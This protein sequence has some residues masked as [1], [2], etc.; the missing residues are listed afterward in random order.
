MEICR[1]ATGCL[2]RVSAALETPS[3]V[4]ICLERFRSAEKVDKQT[5]ATEYASATLNRLREL[6]KSEHGEKHLQS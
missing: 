1:M 6:L 5:A 2:N 3:A 4:E